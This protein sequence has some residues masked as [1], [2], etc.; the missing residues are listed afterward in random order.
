MAQSIGF[1]GDQVS[2]WVASGQSFSLRFLPGGTHI[3]QPRWIPTRR[4]PGGSRTCVVS[5]NFSLIL[6]VGG[7]LL[8]PCS[9]PGP[10]VVK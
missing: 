10:P 9:L 8:V 1:Y 5:F 2:F 4:I 3:A 6:P 7:G